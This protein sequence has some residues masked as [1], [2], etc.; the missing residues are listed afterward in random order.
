MTRRSIL[1]FSLIGLFLAASGLVLLFV[2]TVPY[3]TSRG[4]LDVLAKDGS[5]EMYSQAVYQGLRVPAIITG[6]LFLV[7][8]GLGLWARQSVIF[9]IEAGFRLPGWFISRLIL[10]W[11]ALWDSARSL[12]I[13]W[14]EYLLVSGLILLALFARGALLMI[15]MDHD[16]AYTIVA[17][18]SGPLKE[19][20]SDYHHPNNHLFHTLLAHFSIGAF[21]L[22]P[23]SVRLPAFLMGIL[24]IPVIYLFTRV[25]YGKETALLAAGFSAAYPG[26]ISMS[27]NARGYTTIVV[28]TIVILFLAYYVLSHKSLLGWGL[29]VFFSVLGFYTIPIFLFS[30]AVMVAWVG[31]AVLLFDRQKKAYRSKWEFFLWLAGSGFVIGLLTLALYSPVIIRY[32]GFG[33]LTSGVPVQESFRDFLDELVTRLYDNYKV[34]MQRLPSF[35]AP[36]AGAGA[37]FSLLFPIRASED[38]KKMARLLP[39][40][41]VISSV[42]IVLVMRVNIYPRF[43]SFF[44][45]LLIIWIAAGWVGFSSWLLQRLH[46]PGKV[47]QT[48]LLLT[49]AGIVVTTV[50]NVIHQPYA[51]FHK[52]GD[53]EK[54]ALYLQ[55]N[56]REDDLVVVSPPHDAKLWYYSRLINLNM[57]HYKREL[58]FFRAF[59]VVDP[60]YGET[61]ESVLIERGPELFFFDLSRTRVVFQSGMVTLVECIPDPDLIRSEYNLP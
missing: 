46:L 14:T 11:R 2:F 25:V 6:I 35:F 48:I 9:R 27:V 37:V 16:E 43:V 55:E 44:L 50:V 23:W 40:A 33:I 22:S 10:D 28:F 49:L 19:G 61:V 7:A 5:L 60:T 39:Y 42:I 4:W 15:P 53:I 59:I 34:W 18:A 45:P 30:Y 3:P 56:L 54:L 26:F 8:L 17:F 36:F 21:G 58:P 1:L 31:L 41:A 57:D 52:K 12:Q 32:R 24:L 13:R 38:S 47:F 51:G 20:L 29:L